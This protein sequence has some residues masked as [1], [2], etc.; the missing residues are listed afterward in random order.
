MNITY[1]F[2]VGTKLVI[3]VVDS[4]DCNDCIFY[5]NNH[6]IDGELFCGRFQRKD[7]TDICFKL[8]EVKEP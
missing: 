2:Q 6:C 1:D 5:R 4:L 7:K 3:E 8:V